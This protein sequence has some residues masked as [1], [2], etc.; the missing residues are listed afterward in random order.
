M[1]KQIILLVCVLGPLSIV[2]QSSTRVT[3][4]AFHAWYILNGYTKISGK[5]S[6]FHD[7]HIRRINFGAN[8]QQTLLRGG[9]AYDATDKVQIIGGYARALT[10][11]YGDYPVKFAFDENRSWEQIQIK[12]PLGKL[13]LFQRYR[14]EQRWIGSSALGGFQSPRYENRMRFMGRLNYPIPTKGKIGLYLNVFDEIFV[15]FGK[16]VAHNVFDQ[17]RWG[18]NLGIQFSK[19]INLEIGYLLQTLQHRNPI[20]TTGQ[21]VFEQNN[22]FTTTIVT[23]F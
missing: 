10:Y 18:A 14:L 15:N 3:V 7:I 23:K 12:Q 17:N 5:V 21:D 20:A 19:N 16:K 2:A 11:P 8:P 9:I 13:N 22:T 1:M 4:P 6:F